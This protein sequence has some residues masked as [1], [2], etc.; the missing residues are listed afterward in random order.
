MRP[1]PPNNVIVL[2]FRY[3]VTP[4]FFDDVVHALIELAPQLLLVAA[5]S[6]FSEK[7]R[8]VGPVPVNKLL[9]VGLGG[10]VH[11]I[12]HSARVIL[13]EPILGVQNHVAHDGKSFLLL[14]VEGSLHLAP[15]PIRGVAMYRGLGRNQHALC[16]RPCEQNGRHLCREPALDRGREL[17]RFKIS[18]NFGI[19]V[20]LPPLIA[21][22]FG[23]LPTLV[24]VR[25]NQRSKRPQQ[26]PQRRQRS[27]KEDIADIAQ[28][29]AD[30]SAYTL[31]A[32]RR[33][34]QR[35][36]RDGQ[37]RSQHRNSFQGSRRII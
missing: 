19:I 31:L 29:G 30:L 6:M 20:F 3:W 14:L 33:S 16:F 4:Q 22:G 10:V 24:L 27:E 32:I 2:R 37:E 17:L 18:E 36:A 5:R 26:Q 34:L 9:V 28:A 12:D 15:L 11:P 8:P 7:S 13:Y 21:S 35:A 23:V 1:N 25:L